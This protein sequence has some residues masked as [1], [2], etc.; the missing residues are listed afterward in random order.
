MKNTLVVVAD[1]KEL[2]AY[3]LNDDAPHSSPR[4]ELLEQFRTAANRKLVEEVT[5]Q[6]GRFPRATVAPNIM[7]G[8]S[9]GER[10]NIELEKRK[11][12]TRQLANQI[13]SLLQNSEFERC[14][15]AA[16]REINHA[17]MEELNPRSRAKIEM[18]LAADL[19]KAD[20]S[21]LL[22]RFKPACRARA[23]VR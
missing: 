22:E 12:C 6:A 10:H 15:V 21:D 2:K 5:D 9:Q 20:K 4:L 23:V 8:M 13:D 3:R 16:S 19:T 11:R 18:T 17:L 7:G 1:L 14:F